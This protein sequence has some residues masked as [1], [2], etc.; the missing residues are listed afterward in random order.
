V[1]LV[2]LNVAFWLRDLSPWTLS[3][4]LGFG[5][6]FIGSVMGV[7]Q[8]SVQIAAGPAMLG[9]AAASVQFSRSTGAA[10]GTALVGAL[11]FATLTATDGEAARMLVLILQ[12]GP[13]VLS[14]LPEA[15]QVVV[16]SE[17]VG[18]FRAA[19]LLMAAFA[20]AAMVLVW[21]LPVRRL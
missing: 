7:V 6:L 19:F 1:V 21:T 3:L 13:D 14:S 10:V 17:I 4:V 15:R 9:T 20:T 16:Q 18:A 8:I 5:S 2:F 11:L 12:Q